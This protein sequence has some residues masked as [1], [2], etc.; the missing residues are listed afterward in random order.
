MQIHSLTHP[1][2]GQPKAYLANGLIGLRLGPIPL[3]GPEARLSGNYELSA[4]FNAQSLAL[5]PVPVGADLQLNGHWLSERPDE[6]VFVSQDYDFSTG[7][8][9]SV[10][11]FSDN[12][13]T[14]SVRV[15]TFCSRTRPTIVAQEIQIEVSAEGDLVVQAHLDSRGL[16]G[17]RRTRIQPPRGVDGAL[18]WASRGGEA[19][20]GAAYA[21]EWLNSGAALRRNDF[22]YEDDWLLSRY[23]V[24]AKPGTVYTLR[25][26]GSLVPSVLHPEPHW[27]AIR[28]LR[29]AREAGFEALREANRAA[30]AEL[31]R[32]RIRLTGAGERW[33]AIADAAF[34]YLHSS[35][36]PA[37]PCAIAPFGLSRHREYR[38]NVFWDCDTFMVPPLLLTAPRAARAVLDY[39]FDRLGAARRNAR[40][41]GYDGA[42]FPWQSSLSGAEMTGFYVGA[43]GGI[44]EQH[45]NLDVAMAF[46]QAA[47]IGGDERFIREQAWPILSEVARWIGSRVI[48]TRRG[49][50]IRHVT[51]I[52]E[53][54][55][56]T[57]N[58]IF[59]NASCI[60]VLREAAALSRRLGDEPPALWEEIANHLFIPLDAGALRQHDADE[61]DGKALAL[62][63]SHQ[64]YMIKGADVQGN[65]IRTPEA[66]AAL[67]PLGWSHSPEV[68]LATLRRELSVVDNYAG[69]PMLGAFLGVYA[70]RLGDRKRSLEL[71]EKGSAAYLVEP[72]HQFTEVALEH[73]KTFSGSVTLFLTNPCGFLLS[74]LVGLPGLRTDSGSPSEWGR[75]PVCLPEGWDAIEVERIYARGREWRLIA[76][77]GAARAQLEP[78]S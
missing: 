26:L 77:Q 36:H 60:V 27:Q 58:N 22:G 66:L 13:V 50:E 18:H 41:N 78:L 71:F 21:S 70:A 59:T 6:A 7:E 49:Y 64:N 23:S 32:G 25:Q 53:R 17:D 51:G 12:G 55:D 3:I 42:Q 31:W 46:V 30:W 69:M 11:R 4:E 44:E 73:R 47:H 67:F 61:F 75:H 52:D 62:K 76:E 1:F 29:S 40:M 39:R 38:G 56:G 68:D 45:I 34:F 5:A 19:S 10:F 15:L 54:Q 43:S 14:A 2:P 16:S 72:F 37:T 24:T 20:W 9:A 35:A 57:H 74:L 33:Q 65:W 28:L 48:R 63:T 8:L